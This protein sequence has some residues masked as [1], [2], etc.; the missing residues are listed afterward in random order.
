M[1]YIINT[2]LFL[3]IISLFTSCNKEDS[4]ND[5]DLLIG[6]WSQKP[7]KYET[8]VFTFFD[9]NTAIYFLEQESGHVDH[10]TYS[11]NKD[12]ME[13][14]TDIADYEHIGYEDVFIG[15]RVF[16]VKLSENMLILTN[17]RNNETFVLFR[18]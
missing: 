2:L 18:Q 17:K 6:T 16:S 11:F 1:K 9:D 10:F 4:E 13:I 15:Y 12:K 8:F 14:T 5:N 3:T 7:D